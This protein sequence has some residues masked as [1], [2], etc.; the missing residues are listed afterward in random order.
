MEK[1]NDRREL[2]RGVEIAAPMTSTASARRS[3]RSSGYTANSSNFWFEADP[4]LSLP[5]RVYLTG[6]PANAVVK[7][8]EKKKD[9]KRNVKKRNT[10]TGLRKGNDVGE[11]IKKQDSYKE[12]KRLEHAIK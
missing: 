3:L 11:F 4:G 10:R 12:N 2:Q 7:A 1:K 8:T 9:S 5:P 6:G